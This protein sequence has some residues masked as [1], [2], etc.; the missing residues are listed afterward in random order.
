MKKFIQ[1]MRVFK[2]MRAQGRK[3]VILCYSEE[4]GYH[5][6]PAY[7]KRENIRQFSFADEY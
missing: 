7:G 4:S 6:K 2:K 5:I 1:I 3:D